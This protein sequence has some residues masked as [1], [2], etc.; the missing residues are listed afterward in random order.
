MTEAVAQKLHWDR[1]YFLENITL[2]VKNAEGTIEN[3][4]EKQPGEKSCESPSCIINENLH[5]PAWKF[6]PYRHS[7]IRLSGIYF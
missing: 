7:D 5:F 2:H 1:K 4:E 6:G 3:E